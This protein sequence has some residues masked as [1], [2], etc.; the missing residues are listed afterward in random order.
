MCIH[1]QQLTPLDVYHRILRFNNYV[2]AMVNK[3]ILPLKYTMP[4]LGDS[5]FLSTGLKFNID[6]VLFK[7]PWAPFNQW[8]LREDYKRVAKRKELA[9]SL[10]THIL[11]LGCVNLADSLRTHILVLG[12]V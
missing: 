12:C 2:V 9:D 6:L 10:R 7:S 3:A 1:K 8:H 5:V 4:V 11:V